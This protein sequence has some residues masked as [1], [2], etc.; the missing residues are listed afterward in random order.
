MYV[1]G[2]KNLSS[3]SIPVMYVREYVRW[4]SKALFEDLGRGGCISRFR[5]VLFDGGEETGGLSALGDEEEGAIAGDRVST[6]GCSDGREEGT[7]RS[8]RL[9]LDGEEKGAIVEGRASTDGSSTG[10]EEGTCNRGRFA[11]GGEARRVGEGELE[12]KGRLR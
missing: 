1:M 3:E 7:S 12:A 10:G 5:D 4:V 11:A 6:A 9:V 2:L 8:G